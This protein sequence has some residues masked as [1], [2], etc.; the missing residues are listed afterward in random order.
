MANSK[1]IIVEGAQGAGKTTITDY[2]RHTIPYTNLYR[3]SGTADSTPTGRAKSEK[4]Y[5]DL[6]DYIEKLQN[7]SINLLFDRT[8][9]TE[10]IYCRLGF[11]EYTFSDIYERLLN[12]LANMD[13]EIYYITLYLSDENEFEKRLNRAGKAKNAYARFNKQSSINQQNAYL[14]MADEIAEKYP[15]INVVKLDNCRDE[16]VVKEEIK[17]MLEW[18]EK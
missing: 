4:M 18:Q 3:L 7:M 11:K 9:F 8:F 15:Q 16:K 17:N 14:K 12:R 6:V 1:I 5:I 13:F 2:I 10:E